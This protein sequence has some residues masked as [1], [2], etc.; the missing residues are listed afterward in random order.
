VDWWEGRAAGQDE[1]IKMLKK[2]KTLREIKEWLRAIDQ[3]R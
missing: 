1:I 3:S 2:G